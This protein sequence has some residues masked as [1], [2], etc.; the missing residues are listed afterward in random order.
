MGRLVTYGIL[1]A[2]ISFFG[3]V[4]SLYGI[5][6]WISWIVGGLLLVIGVTGLR[7]AP[8]RFILT[9]LSGF[10]NFLKVRFAFLLSMKSKY[11][12]I[13]MGMINGLLPCGVTWLALAYCITLQW[14]L[15]GF[16]AMGLFGLGTLPA[17]IAFPTLLDTLTKRLRLS[18]RSIQTALLILSGVVLIGRTFT[19]HQLPQKD[20]IVICGTNST[21]KK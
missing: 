8:P 3:G 21:I 5:E 12:L 2:V 11:G 15:D 7:V 14:P 6:N 10:S 4:A 17:M 20:G 19:I 16:L 9:P 13:A 18:F 1:G